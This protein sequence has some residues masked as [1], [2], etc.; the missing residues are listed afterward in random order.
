VIDVLDDPRLSGGIRLGAEI[1]SSY[2]A[3]HDSGV[4]V[5]YGDIVG[6]R[7]I[8]KR[9]GYLGERIGADES[10]LVACEE[11]LSAGFPL[12][13]PTQPRRPSRSRR[14]R[15]TTNVSLEAPESS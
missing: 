4:L 3:Q 10:L 13:D 2:L 5:E 7:T 6:N 15:L 14:W 1:L 12:L 11:R 8:F 9:I